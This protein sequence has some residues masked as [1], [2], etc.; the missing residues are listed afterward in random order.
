MLHTLDPFCALCDQA[1]WGRQSGVAT[2]TNPADTSSPSSI[3]V[4]P[5]PDPPTEHHEDAILDTPSLSP[6]TEHHDN[7]ILD[8]PFPPP[9]VLDPTTGPLTEH[10]GDFAVVS[11]PLA[12]S[13]G[14]PCHVPSC[15]NRR[16]HLSQQQSA[17]DCA[18]C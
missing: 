13:I 9:I 4:D 8:T 6:I 10:H 16:A 11:H 17:A 5:T 15:H 2:H 12:A 1:A 3:A 18:P 7:A 14:F